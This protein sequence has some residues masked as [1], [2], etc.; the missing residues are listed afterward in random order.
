VRVGHAGGLVG[1][2]GSLRTRLTWRDWI[3]SDEMR[4]T[5]VQHFVGGREEADL[6]LT[7]W[8]SWTLFHHV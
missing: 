1:F 2:S 5:K 8:V 3:V 7:D 4:F 6:I